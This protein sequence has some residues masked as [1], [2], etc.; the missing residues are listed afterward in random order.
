MCRYIVDLSSTV[1]YKTIQNYVSGVISLNNYYGHDVKCI[2]SEFTF[3]TT[4]AGIRRVLGDPTPVRP[5]FTLSDILSM[6][7]YVDL[8]SSSERGMW[9][10]LALSFRSL[11]RKSNL[12]PDTL[13]NPVGHYIRRGALSFTSWGLELTVSSSKTIQYG[14][15]VFKV[16]ITSA[17]GSPLCAASLVLA[18]CVEFPS[19]DLMS[20][21]F[22]VRK[23]D[24]VV[25]LTYPALL[26]FLKK[27]LRS[28]GLEKERAGMHSMR[29]AGALYMYNLGLSIE[30]IRQ[31]GDWASMAALLYLTKPFQ[32]RI[33]TDIVVSKGLVCGW[34]M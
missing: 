8:R 4:M 9:A 18:H 24:T 26:A 31:A 12:V 28:A 6:Y 3:I 25:P 29:R 16:P 13:N 7:R 27:L 1:R 15:R 11:L 23:K 32:S 10:C 33:D 5:S 20:P 34:E 22:M 14:Q 21:V 17:P 2:R 19:D 30:D